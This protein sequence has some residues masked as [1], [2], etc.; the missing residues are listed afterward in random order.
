MIQEIEEVVFGLSPEKRIELKARLELKN[1]GLT[2]RVTIVRN[3]VH[4]KKWK[5]AISG[6]TELLQTLPNNATLLIARGYAHYE[7]GE[8]NSMDN[9]IIDYKKCVKEHPLYAKAWYRMA[10]AYI[11]KRKLKKSVSCLHKALELDPTNEKYRDFIDRTQTRSDQDELLENRNPKLEKVI[12]SVTLKEDAIKIVE[13][14]GYYIEWLP[15]QL[16]DTKEVAIAAVKQCG[17]TIEYTNFCDDF[18]VACEAVKQCPVAIKLISD[19]LKRDRRLALEAVGRNGMALQF[20]PHYAD[21]REIVMT[22]IKKTPKSFA[23]AAKELRLD[24]DLIYLS[25]KATSLSF[26]SNCPSTLRNNKEFMMKVVQKAPNHLRFASS[27]LRNDKDLCLL[28][29][30][31]G[32]ENLEYCGEKMIGN[33]EVVSF[34]VEKN[35]LAYSFADEWLRN[36]K[37]ILKLA[38]PWFARLLSDRNAKY[39]DVHIKYE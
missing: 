35:R 5:Q 14:N 1:A 38:S 18:D 34:A 7:S 9:S 16:Q 27:E 30:E 15:E 3:F 6:Y 12:S 23:Y 25:V 17:S 29:L 39:N 21:D 4:T 11:G 22:A 36:D 26:R 33:K 8:Q 32:G 19:R 20:M 10:N 28:A 2:D 31:Q 37:D 24:Q 13:G